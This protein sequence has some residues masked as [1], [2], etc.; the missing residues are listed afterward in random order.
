MSVIAI[1]AFFA[2]ASVSPPMLLISAAEN[3]V[4]VSMYSLADSPAVL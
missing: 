3:P 2:A 1:S 4:T